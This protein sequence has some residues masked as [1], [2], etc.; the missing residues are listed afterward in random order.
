MSRDWREQARCSVDTCPVD[1]F[2][3]RDEEQEKAKAYC[4]ACPVAAE[5]LAYAMNVEAHYSEK[6]VV[7]CCGV[8][9]GKDG[10]E[11]VAIRRSQ[12][13]GR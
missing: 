6:I 13:K 9:G 11:R 3:Q 10:K 5:C 4:E 7:E 8:W 2:D 12:V 1:F